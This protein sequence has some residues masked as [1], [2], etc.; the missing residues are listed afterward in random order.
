VTDHKVRSRR[1]AIKD[2]QERQLKASRPGIAM[3]IL[4]AVALAQAEMP[5]TAE[6]DLS[7]AEPEILVA[8]LDDPAKRETAASEIKN[9]LER[10]PKANRFAYGL[11]AGWSKERARLLTPEEA[12]DLAD[13]YDGLW[14]CCLKAVPDLCAPGDWSDRCIPNTETWVRGDRVNTIDFI[15]ERIWELLEPHHH[16]S[17][18]ELLMLALRG[19]FKNLPR[20]IRFDLIDLIRKQYTEKARTLTFL[21]F[22]KDP[23]LLKEASETL[24]HPNPYPQTTQDTID[25]MELL[26]IR[27]DELISELGEQSYETLLAAA[28]FAQS[29][30]YP[31]S[32]QARKSGLTAA[33]ANR[34]GVGL[35]R[36]TELKRRLR[37][38]MT[39]ARRTGKPTT[40][41]LLFQLLDS[42]APNSHGE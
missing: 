19:S 40:T 3:Q 32:K 5:E 38:Q 15:Q 23:H 4:A 29:N 8:A 34:L 21:S 13:A 33:V 6:T 14:R 22:D 36:A 17:E 7:G 37:E 41:V 35:R 27:K 42:S 10:T 12:A 25:P 9:R 30:D 31:D 11:L 2:K 18:Q 16:L 39:E 26:Y 24:K 20:E 1:R 28:D